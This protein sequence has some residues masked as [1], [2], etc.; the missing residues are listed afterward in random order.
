MA[1]ILG[2]IKKWGGNLLDALEAYGSH[3]YAPPAMPVAEELAG[4]DAA[5]LREQYDRDFRVA[6]DQAIR[7]GAG[8]YVMDDYGHSGAAGPYGTG[9]SQA[10][11]RA[12][13]LREQRDTDA[14]R[15]ALSDYI[16]QAAGFSQDDEEYLSPSDQALLQAIGPEKA[17]ELLSK[18]QFPDATGADGTLSMIQGGDGFYYRVPRGGGAPVNTG[19]PVPDPSAV[20]TDRFRMDGP[21]YLEYLQQKAFTERY[22]KDSAE[23]KSEAEARLPS[24][25]Q[26]MTS[27]IARLEA[28]RDRVAELPSGRI[29]GWMREQFDAEFQ[30]IAA[31]LNEAALENIAALADRGVRL[32]PITEKELELLLSTSAQLKNEPAANVE[33]LNS[34]IASFQARLDAAIDLLQWIDA[35]N[36]VLSYRPQ[37]YRDMTGGTGGSGAQ[38]APP[39]GTRVLPSGEE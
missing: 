28:V 21:A 19:I 13:A 1:D 16:A 17:A 22:E 36:P 5:G 11:L 10:V 4:A 31:I 6:R 12:R 39:P 25:I 7:G 26:G 15:K 14:R 9:L 32:N 35:G 23:A 33:I 30:A 24:V 38:A 3:Q 29:E 27:A 34:R 20:Q 8:W 37:V 18:R 2:G